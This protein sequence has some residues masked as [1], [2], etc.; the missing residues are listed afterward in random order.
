MFLKYLRVFTFP[1]WKLPTNDFGSWTINQVKNPWGV[2]DRALNQWLQPWLN[3]SISWDIISVT[4]VVYPTHNWNYTPKYV[5]HSCHHETSTTKRLVLAHQRN[6]TLLITG[7]SNLESND[8]FVGPISCTR[9]K[10]LPHNKKNICW[11]IYPKTSVRIPL[12]NDNCATNDLVQRSF[13]LESIFI[14]QR[15]A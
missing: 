2:Q 6:C 1:S 15:K 7:R 10:D 3:N 9:R 11:I 8:H 12:E 4:M 5:H 14:V 13:W